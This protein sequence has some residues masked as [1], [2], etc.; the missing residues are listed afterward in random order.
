MDPSLRLLLFN[1]WPT[2]PQLEYHQV[3]LSGKILI[4]HWI[5]RLMCRKFRS[6]AMS[7]FW[8]KT[9]FHYVP[10]WDLHYFW[11]VLHSRGAWCGSKPVGICACACI[12]NQSFSFTPP[13]AKM[14]WI[15]MHRHAGRQKYP[16]KERDIHECC[17]LGKD[18]PLPFPWGLYLHLLP[19]AHAGCW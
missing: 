5:L 7:L 16:W 8:V 13:F 15:C 18:S 4:S 9:Y 3:S 11:D 14:I 2:E 12:S 6:P 17:T 10:P 1:S 19:T